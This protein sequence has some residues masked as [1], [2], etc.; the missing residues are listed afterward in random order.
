MRVFCGCSSK[1]QV[2]AQ[3]VQSK[4]SGGHRVPSE[5]RC[6]RC[7]GKENGNSIE[8]SCKDRVGKAMGAIARTE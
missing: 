7:S 6:F 5:Y 1:Y 2:S 8:C 4:Y 3:P